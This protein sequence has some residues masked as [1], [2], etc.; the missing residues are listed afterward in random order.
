VEEWLE[1]DCPM[2]RYNLFHCYPSCAWKEVLK[3]G[4]SRR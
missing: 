1:G 2:G 3:E 4:S